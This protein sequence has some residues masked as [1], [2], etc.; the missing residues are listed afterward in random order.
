MKSVCCIMLANGRPEMVRRAV[1]S[2]HSQEYERKR[3]LIWNTGARGDFDVFEAFDVSVC[4]SPDPGAIGTLRNR[5]NSAAVDLFDVDVVAHLDS[6]DWSHPR[7]LADQVELLETSRADIVGYRDC[8]FWDSRAE[9]R[10]CSRITCQVAGMHIGTC[11]GDCWLYRAAHPKHAIGASMIYPGPRGIAS[12]F[13]IARK[14]RTPSGCCTGGSKFTL[15]RP[16]GGGTACPTTS[17]G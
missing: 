2:F 13:P 9:G 8:L 6:D 11:V 5:A 17:R 3:L 14:G 1:A 7:R 16:P 10:A 12:T 15:C 4:Y